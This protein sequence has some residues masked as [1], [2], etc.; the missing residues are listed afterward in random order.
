MTTLLNF[1]KNLNIENIQFFKPTK[2]GKR[3]FAELPNGE[4]IF[5]S[6]KCDLSLPLYVVKH[7]PESAPDS[8]CYWVCNS[9]LKEGELL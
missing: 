1:K 4:S 2:G 7:A 3:Q 5:I 8:E 9:T 6:S